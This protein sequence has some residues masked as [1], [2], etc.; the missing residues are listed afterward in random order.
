M[1]KPVGLQV[2]FVAAAVSLCCILTVAVVL[3]VLHIQLDMAQT[4]LL[5]RM[6]AFKVG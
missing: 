3:P 5:A 6:D 2:P 4:R 1:E